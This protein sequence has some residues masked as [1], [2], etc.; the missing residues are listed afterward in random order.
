M[1]WISHL[2]TSELGWIFREQPT[3]D[4]GIDAHL[5]V[6]DSAASTAT[7]QLLASGFHEVV[8]PRLDHER[9]KCS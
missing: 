2:V 8:C 4:V 6:V 3:V 7:G 1:A 5:E 9:E